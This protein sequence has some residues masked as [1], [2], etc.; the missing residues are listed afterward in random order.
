MSSCEGSN[1]SVPH[2]KKGGRLRH[3]AALQWGVGELL[4]DPVA[5]KARILFVDAGEKLSVLSQ[6]LFLVEGSEPEDPMLD[7]PIRSLTAKAHVE[8]EKR[9]KRAISGVQPRLPRGPSLTLTDVKNRFL[10]RFP[11]GFSDA[12][13]R[14]EERDYKIAAHELARQLLHNMQFEAAS[15]SGECDAI[16]RNAK[17][18]LRKTNLVFRLELIKFHAG[19]NSEAGRR[20]FAARL[21]ALLFGQAAELE[22]RFTS[23][24]DFLRDIGAPNWTLA[25]YFLFIVF[26]MSSC[27]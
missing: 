14:T 4:E 22:D 21:Q 9:G 1:L 23:F 5:G 24:C 11:G 15:Q 20:L 8:A 13:Y 25:T 27:S 12:K 6:Q 18:V 2:L 10:S 7:R 26:P 17:K 3:A 16:W 19:V